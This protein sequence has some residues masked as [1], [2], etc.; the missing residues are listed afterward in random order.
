MKK[1][2]LRKHWDKLLLPFERSQDSYKFH[3]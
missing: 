3:F 2:I 1:Y